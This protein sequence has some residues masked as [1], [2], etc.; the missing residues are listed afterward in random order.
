MIIGSDS[1]VGDPCHSQQQF[2]YTSP[3]SLKHECLTRIAL[4]F[5][6]DPYS[7]EFEKLDLNY[8]WVVSGRLPL[9]SAFTKY[10][11]QRSVAWFD[12]PH[13][14][15]STKLLPVIDF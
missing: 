6:P 4:H 7:P 12:F 1:D 2:G 9:P 11:A 15:N 10:I 14:K 3:T 5:M 8:C 13:Y